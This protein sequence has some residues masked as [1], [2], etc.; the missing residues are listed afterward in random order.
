M[1]VSRVKLLENSH[2]KRNVSLKESST[3]FW[4]DKLKT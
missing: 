3:A 4:Q 1:S 2:L